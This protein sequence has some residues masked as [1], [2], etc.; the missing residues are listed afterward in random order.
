VHQPLLDPS[1]YSVSSQEAGLFGSREAAYDEIVGVVD[2][3]S[4]FVLLDRAVQIHGIPV[5]LI[6][7][8]A[9]ANGWVSGAQVERQIWITL[10]VHAP[11]LPLERHQSEHPAADLEHGNALS[12][13][14]VLYRPGP[15]RARLEDLV[16]RHRI[17]TMLGWCRRGW[18]REGRL[19]DAPRASR[20]RRRP[21]RRGCRQLQ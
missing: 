9:G 15:T 16:P 17:N 7:V 2:H 14:V 18:G 8:I 21:S 19:F 1:P 13:R 3:F 11:R 10:Q 20:D 4:K 5:A 6:R 12:K